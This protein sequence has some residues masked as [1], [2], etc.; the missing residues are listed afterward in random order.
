ASIGLYGVLSY[1]VAQRARELGL[2]IALGATATSVER[3]VVTRGLVL[4]G[5]GLGIGTVVAWAAT[6]ALQ[7]QLY[8]VTATH[9]WTVAAVLTLL[10]A[11][12]VLASY[13][14]ARRAARVDPIAVLRAD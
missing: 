4:T 7:N 5:T 2:R 3:L 10:A 6:R 11:I 1:A 9:P 13:V 14:P 8:G 12:A